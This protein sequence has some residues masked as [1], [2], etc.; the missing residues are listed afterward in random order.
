[1]LSHQNRSYHL[2]PASGN[3]KVFTVH[4]HLVEDNAELY[5]YLELLFKIM[6]CMH[7]L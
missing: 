3:F 2:I 4:E 7:Q 5:F 6:S 1:M